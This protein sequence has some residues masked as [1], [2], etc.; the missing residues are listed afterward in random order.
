[1]KRR[2]LD[3]IS[4]LQSEVRVGEQGKESGILQ[5]VYESQDAAKAE[6]LVQQVVEAYVRQNVDRGSAEAAAQL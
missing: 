5:V 2:R 3:V 6:A 4:G 1:M